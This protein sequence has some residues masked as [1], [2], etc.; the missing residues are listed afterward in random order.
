MTQLRPM[1]GQMF[2]RGSGKGLLPSPP[3]ELPDTAALFFWLQGGRVVEARDE[4][5]M[6]RRQRGDNVGEMGS[7]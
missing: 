1:K 5:D 7:G 6:G 2:A 4:N 3:R